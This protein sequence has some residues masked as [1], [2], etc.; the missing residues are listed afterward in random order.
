MMRKNL[1][2]LFVLAGISVNLWSQTCDTTIFKN[3]KQYFDTYH[4]FAGNPANWMH[5]NTHD[6]TVNKDGE[7]F[8]MYSTDASWGGVNENGALKRRSKDL[9]NWEFLGNAFDGVPQSA[10]DFFINNG[11]PSYTDQGIWAP[12]LFKH[13]D[14]YILYYSAPGGLN[15]VNFAY[16]GYATSDSASGPWEDQGMITYSY[17]DNINAIDPSV[18]YD[19]VEQ[20]LWMAYGSWFSG[21][22]ILELDTATGGIKTP[23]DRGTKIANRATSA[24]GLEGPELIYRNGWYY[25]FVTYDP[26]GDIYNVRVGRSKNAQGPY[27]DFNG[28]PMT[29]LADNIPMIH[30]PYRFK[31]HPGWQGTGH[32]GVYNENGQYYMFNQGRPTIQPAMMVLHVRKIFWMNDWPIVSPERYAGVPQCSITAD[33]LTGNWEH[34]PLVYKT[35]PSNFHSTSVTIDLSADGTIGGNATSTWTYTDDTLTLNWYSGTATH[36]LIVSWGWDWENNCKTLLYTGMDTKGG[37]I[38]GKKIVQTEVDRYNTLVPGAAYMI[39]S[40]YSNLVLEIP[41]GNDAVGTAIRQGTENGKSFQHWRLLDAGNGYYKLKSMASDSVRVME[42]YN[43]TNSN[44]IGIAVGTNNGYSKNK[45]KIASNSNNGSYRMLTKVSND[46]RCVDVNGFSVVPGGTI[47]QW[48]YLS[49]LN[50]AWR[51]IRI[52]TLGIDTT[53]TWTTIIS[54]SKDF[55]VDENEMLQLYPNPNNGIFTVDVPAYLVTD[56]TICV[57]NTSGQ[58]IY[59]SFVAD[60]NGTHLVTVPDISKGYYFVKIIAGERIINKGMMVY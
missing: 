33:S 19:S 26:L 38:W 59:S 31:N 28:N 25:L 47:I 5:F 24:N 22:Y 2:I 13:K 54:N 39:R 29:N 34:M 60:N 42:V 41:N 56:F 4:E 10:V 16:L 52:D 18:V 23:G 55:E 36:K 9:V 15:N 6:P 14:K 48:E 11:N 50:Q 46:V 7:W 51:F 37:C 57:Y 12:Y 17:R 43:G 20:R 32:C 27:Y 1:L 21:L 40:M 3:G 49:G 58:L 35:S 53:G 8:Y 44:G 30:S 45:F